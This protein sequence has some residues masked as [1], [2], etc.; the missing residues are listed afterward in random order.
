MEDRSSPAYYIQGKFEQDLEIPPRPTAPPLILQRLPTA[1]LGA[2]AI[3]AMPPPT[4]GARC[5]RLLPRSVHIEEMR[6][7]E[8]RQRWMSF[9]RRGPRDRNLV[10]LSRFS[11]SPLSRFLSLP[12]PPPAC[13]IL[14]PPGGRRRIVLSRTASE[15]WR[16]TRRGVRLFKSSNHLLWATPNLLHK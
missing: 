11:L 9:A 2:R 5:A 10:S 3:G 6:P 4:A 1:A 12:L 13:P 14:V 15:A 16:R 8:V 7:D